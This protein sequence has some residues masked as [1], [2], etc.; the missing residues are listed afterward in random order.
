MAVVVM[1]ALII[2][3]LGLLFYGVARQATRLA[4]PADATAAI[5]F[6]H[7]QLSIP[8]HAKFH[9]SAPMA[10]GEVMLTFS[11][12]DGAGYIIILAPDRQSI[13]A[14]LDIAPQSDNGNFSLD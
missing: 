10:N 4:T 13:S 1:S 7:K 11:G 5:P 6:V 2:V 8:A 3:G 12:A 14:R 9:S